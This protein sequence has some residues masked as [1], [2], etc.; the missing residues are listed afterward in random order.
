MGSE[1]REL[2][3]QRELVRKWLDAEEEGFGHTLEQGLKRLDELIERA[4]DAGAEGIA[5][6]DAFL[7]HDTYGFPIDMTLEIVAEHGLGV[8]EQGFESLMTDQRSRARAAGGRDHDAEA[9]RE[10]AQVLA[11]DAGAQ[12]EFVGYE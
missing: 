6:A 8:D 3:D 11:G 5:G 2:R 10:R 12:T 9:R 1:Y 7:L 4:R